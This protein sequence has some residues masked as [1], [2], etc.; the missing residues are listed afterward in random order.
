MSIHET[1]KITPWKLLDRTDVYSDEPWV[2]LSK[3]RVLLPNGVEI[4][5]FYRLQC[6]DYAIVA[7]LTP[8]GHFVMERQYKHGTG[9]VSLMLPGG[10]IEKGE[11]PLIAAQRE[12][13]EETGFVAENWHPLGSFVQDA[14]HFLCRGHVFAARHA[15]RATDPRIDAHE[16][17]ET[18]LM[19]PAEIW[20]AIQTGNI[21]MVSATSAFL[22]AAISF[23]LLEF[24]QP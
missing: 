2:H 8:D 24:K 5:N 10:A 17:S 9:K 13:K 4:D 15:V 22:L 20:R 14:N 18:I 16:I 23:D 11:D 3:D 7:A 19:K 21:P 12:L 1:S 6:N